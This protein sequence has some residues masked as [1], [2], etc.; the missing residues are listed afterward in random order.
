MAE[1]SVSKSSRRPV[2]FGRV[3]GRIGLAP[4][5]GVEVLSLVD[6]LQ[7]WIALQL[8][9]EKGREFHVR[10]LQQLD[11]LHQLRRHHQGLSLAHHELG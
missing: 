6:S 7:Q 5:L 11:R 2:A 10:Q 1:R 8:V 3:P 4:L 9:F